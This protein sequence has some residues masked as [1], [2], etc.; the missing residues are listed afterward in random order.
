MNVELA[1]EVARRAVPAGKA[2]A[3]PGNVA[4]IILAV[5]VFEFRPEAVAPSVA[6]RGVNADA[7][8]VVGFAV[9]RQAGGSLR[10]EV[11]LVV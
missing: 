4:H 11:R 1:A 2:E 8:V 6:E 9:E 10:V 5:G 3:V 7:V